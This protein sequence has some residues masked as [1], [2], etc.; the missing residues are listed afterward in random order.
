M[1]KLHVVAR[2]QVNF[3]SSLFKKDDIEKYHKLLYFPNT[4][5][6]YDKT[7]FCETRKVIHIHELLPLF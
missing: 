4:V 5:L 3:M 2:K 7:V 1:T 6:V